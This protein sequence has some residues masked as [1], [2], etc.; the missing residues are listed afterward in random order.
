MR[1][2]LLF[3]DGGQRLGPGFRLFPLDVRRVAKNPGLMRVLDGT[4]R[5]DIYP[6]CRRGVLPFGWAI[7]KAKRLNRSQQSYGQ[8]Q[9]GC[10]GTQ[11]CFQLTTRSGIIPSSRPESR[12]HPQANQEGVLG[13]RSAGVAKA[14]SQD[15]AMNGAGRREGTL[16]RINRCLIHSTLLTSALHAAWSPGSIT[17]LLPNTRTEQA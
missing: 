13:E 5:F 11:R 6:W 2:R 15:G 8:N 17:A 16:R 14:E 1:I 10:I 4:V 9:I 3:D 7:G 12:A